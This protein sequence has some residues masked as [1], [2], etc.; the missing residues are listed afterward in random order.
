MS[1]IILF[2]GYLLAP[3]GKA[4]NT[5]NVLRAMIV[6]KSNLQYLD[7]RYFSESIELRD[8]GIVTFA[9]TKK[10][11]KDFVFEVISNLKNLLIDL[12]FFALRVYVEFEYSD[13]VEI[14]EFAENSFSPKNNSKN[15]ESKMSFFKPA[16]IKID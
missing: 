15:I 16:W 3:T 10:I 14:F 2:N 1:E 8:Y 9:F 12:D 13:L 11:N 6:N 5:R 7:D 4:Q